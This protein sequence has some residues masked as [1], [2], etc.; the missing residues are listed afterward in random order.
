MEHMSRGTPRHVDTMLVVAEPYYRS[1]ETAGRLVP[2]ARELGIPRVMV[3][4]NKV[5]GARDEA[6]IREYCAHH[7]AE[8]AASV[9]F[10]ESVAEA[11]R[12]GEALLD[13]NAGAAAVAAIRG[14]AARLRET[15]DGS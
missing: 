15:G 14:L 10:D 12:E 7:G 4:A 1:L 3:I 9:P 8:L 13:A 5:R 2:L 6:T 11:D